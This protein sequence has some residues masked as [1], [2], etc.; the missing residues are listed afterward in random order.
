MPATSFNA[1]DRIDP[2]GI[3]AAED[4]A[5]LAEAPATD[6]LYQVAKAH[7]NEGAKAVLTPTVDRFDQLLAT[8]Q[9][10]DARTG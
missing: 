8:M 1:L 9:D 7:R 3:D 5:L 4:A 6:P 2:A 10:S